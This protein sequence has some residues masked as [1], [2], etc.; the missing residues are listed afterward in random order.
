V[1]IATLRVINQRGRKRGEGEGGNEGLA[2]LVPGAD[3]LAALI[4]AMQGDNGRGICS[5]RSSVTGRAKQ[6]FRGK[7]G[8]DTPALSVT[9]QEDAVA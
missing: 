5:G 4:L 8:R 3:S 6:K 7:L 1:E 9:V 2:V